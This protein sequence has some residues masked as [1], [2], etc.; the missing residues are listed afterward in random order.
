MSSIPTPPSPSKWVLDNFLESKHYIA[1][2]S[3]FPTVKNASVR[4]DNDIY[5]GDKEYI[6][7]ISKYRPW[8]VFHEMIF[9]QQFWEPYF[10]TIKDFKFDNGH[11]EHRAGV[12][13]SKVTEKFLY[14]RIDV[15]VAGPGYGINNGGRGV[16]VDNKQ[17]IISGLLYFTDQHTIDGGEFC[18]CTP[19]GK[20]SSMHQL[21]QNRAIISHQDT[22]NG[23]HMV[24]PLRRGI[25]K[26]IY[27][28]L[29]ATWSYY[30]R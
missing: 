5:C 28:S 18:F 27:F 21:K 3:C 1:M 16:H 8:Q 13:D 2:H 6:S 24:N 15:G 7:H 12:L 9:S 19:D 23:W 22:E 30:G 20:I 17:R 25:R 4:A 29:N 26:F 10:P 14:S 11:L